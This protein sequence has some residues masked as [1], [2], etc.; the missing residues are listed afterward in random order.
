MG[1]VYIKRLMR[2]LD[3]V[4]VKFV[5]HHSTADWRNALEEYD[6]SDAPFCSGL[7]IDYE[8]K[9]VHSYGNTNIA[10]IIHEAGH[11]V[12]CDKKPADSDEYKFFGWEMAVFQHLK[13]PL[14]LWFTGNKDYQIE[15]EP[16]S[17]AGKKPY[18][19]TYYG[20]VGHF[21]YN[22]KHFKEFVKDRLTAAQEYGVVSE[23]GK[24]L[25]HP[26]RR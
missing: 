20:E 23:E 12:A 15:F 14:K 26:A 22:S 5:E 25:V 9:A 16:E 18:Q 24:P 2:F 19:K 1:Q 11:I 17:N 6:L 8:G 13:I 3:S 10:Q 4:G 7:A 21:K